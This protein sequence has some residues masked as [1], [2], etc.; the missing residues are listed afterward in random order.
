MLDR[1]GEIELL[2]Q[3]HDELVWQCLPKYLGES[4]KFVKRA[5]ERRFKIHGRELY[6]PVDVKVSKLGGSWGRMQGWKD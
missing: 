5:M 3:N 4:I 2:H 6:I 1:E